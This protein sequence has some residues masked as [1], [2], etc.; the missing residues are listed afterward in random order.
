MKRRFFP[1]LEHLKKSDEIGVLFKRGNSVACWGAKLYFARN[2]REYN[3]IAYALPRKFGN[4]VRRN[5]ARRWGREAWRHLRH[6]L[7]AGFDLVLL[8]FPDETADYQRR[9]TQFEN[10]LRK[11]RILNDG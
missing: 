1:K 3:R 5:R 10:L 2:T 7:E 4:A 6:K 9:F 8:V 11:A